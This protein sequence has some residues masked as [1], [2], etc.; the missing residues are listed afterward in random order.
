[1][2]KHGEFTRRQAAR[3]TYEGKAEGSAA[4][5][6]GKRLKTPC[7]SVVIT[8][9]NRAE[10]VPATVESALRQT[11]PPLEV[12]VIDDGSTDETRSVLE[13]YGAPV[14]YVWQPNAER[15]AARNHGL[16]L[17]RGEYIAFLDSD[18]LF[19]PHKL[20]WEVA[21][22]RAH[23]TAALV[24]SDVLLI[25]AAGRPLRRVSRKGYV[26]WVTRYLLRENFLSFSAHLA[27]T[28][29]MRSAGG[30]REDWALAGSE[31]WEAWVRLSTRAPFAY[32]NEVTARIRTHPCNTMS[33]PARM[34]GSMQYACRV[35]ETADCLSPEQRQLLRRRRA[36]VA[37]FAAINHRVSGNRR[38]SWSRLIAALRHSPLVVLEP[39]F[40]YTCLQNLLP[41]CLQRRG[42]RAR[43]A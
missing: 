17:A 23:P 10:Y 6:G 26:G 20:E 43:P 38:E 41:T 16:R 34:E 36:M 19:E 25:D 24:Y 28:E 32:L 33:D 39:R 9:Y 18:D 14:R 7:V 27:R 11:Y 30:F 29:A 21:H 22:L 31:D 37:L 1:V 40:A 3:G 42:Q 15:G 35:M 5:F 8:T 12:I 13:R 4:V 2:R